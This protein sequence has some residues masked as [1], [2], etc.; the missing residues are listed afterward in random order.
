MGTRGGNASR[1]SNPSCPGLP[2]RVGT[3]FD[4]EESY[5]RLPAT[6]ADVTAYIAQRATAA[7]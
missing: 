4:R 5:E 2:S 1:W 6:Y 3:L 7:E